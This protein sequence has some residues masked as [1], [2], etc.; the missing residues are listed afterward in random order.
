MSSI[1]YARLFEVR[2]LHDYYLMK[3]Y[4]ESSVAS[5]SFFLKNANDQETVLKKVL[6]LGQYNALD[7]FEIKPLE[8][9]KKILEQLKIR[10]IPNQLGFFLGMEVNATKTPAGGGA[11]N[12]KYHPKIAPPSGTHLQFSINSK[13]TDLYKRA[14]LP[15]PATLNSRFYFSNKNEQGNKTFPALSEGSSG[16][17]DVSDFNFLPF[18]ISVATSIGKTIKATLADTNGSAIITKEKL[19]TS[20][21]VTLNLRQPNTYVQ[22]APFTQDGI[23]QLTVLENNTGPPPDTHFFSDRYFDE[24]NFGILDFFFDANDVAPNQP[25]N[26]LENNG[27]DLKTKKNIDAVGTITTTTKHPVFELRL[28]GNFS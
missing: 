3:A 2:I 11:F 25:Y 12:I 17:A 15:Q 14:V 18:R 10:V 13:D 19:A 6:K 7:F 16:V 21:R 4:K 23:Y 26:L 8:N 24:S 5:D 9:T 27:K 1:I 20:D 22:D 28:K